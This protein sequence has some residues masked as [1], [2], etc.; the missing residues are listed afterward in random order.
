MD[1]GALDEDGELCH[2]EVEGKPKPLKVHLQEGEAEELALA[3]T[4]L[5]PTVQGAVTVREYSKWFPGEACDL[6]EL[7]NALSEQ[8]SL[9][10]DGKLERGEAMLAVQAHTLDAIYNN[11]ARRAQNAEY[12]SQFDTYLKF[13]LRAQAQCRATWEAIS[14]IQNPPIAGYVNQANIAQ[15]QL[16]N[17]DAGNFET[18]TRTRAQ[19]RKNQKAQSKLLEH[20]DHEPDK[21]LDR[22][23]STTAERAD[24]AVEAVEE[25]TG[26]RT[27]QGKAKVA[28][29]SPN[30]RPCPIGTTV[31]FGR[32]SIR[33]NSAIAS[34]WAIGT[35]S[36][37]PW[38]SRSP[39]GRSSLARRGSNTWENP[40]SEPGRWLGRIP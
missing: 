39:Y 4:V 8:T 19:A 21:W 37:S 23:T 3:R 11:L 26:P 38:R 16:V 40:G 12:L 33:R 25:S 22:G 2:E 1:S 34:D 10:T 36:P 20:V 13:A 28:R 18:S 5:R 32:S 17:N 30:S 27:R 6:G 35:P 24:S 29:N 31:A 14:E 9:V 15:N 7:V